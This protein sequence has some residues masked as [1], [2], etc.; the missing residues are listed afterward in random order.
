[1]YTE[2]TPQ[3]NASAL[4][5]FCMQ[6][7]NTNQTNLHHHFSLSHSFHKQLALFNL[8]PPFFFLFFPLPRTEI[9]NKKKDENFR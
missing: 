5:L 9:S 6:T 3:N 1:M 8:P 2:C 4:L 7:P